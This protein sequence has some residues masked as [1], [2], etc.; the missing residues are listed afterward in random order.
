M[1]SKEA[2]PYLPPLISRFGRKKA[3]Q[4]SGTILNLTAREISKLDTRP[5]QYLQDLN[6][7][8]YFNTILLKLL[9]S[10][11]FYFFTYFN[12]SVHFIYFYALESYIVIFNTTLE[13]FRIYIFSLRCIE[14]L[15]F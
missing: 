3:A 10:I 2:V 9:L 12:I 15:Y 7:V 8:R 13:L 4:H 5:A 6:G 14:M 11:L 1:L